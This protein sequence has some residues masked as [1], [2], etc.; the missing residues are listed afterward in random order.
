IIMP[1]TAKSVNGNTSVAPLSRRWAMS[2]AES[3]TTAAS[4][5]KSPPLV[6]RCSASRSTATSER[7]TM[8]P[9]R[10]SPGPSRA[11]DP[12]S[13][14]PMAN[15]VAFLPLLSTTAMNAA[16]S[17]R[18]VRPTWTGRRLALGTDA[19]IS[20]AAKAAPKTMIMGDR[21]AQSID[22]SLIGLSGGRCFVGFVLDELQ[23][24]VH[25]RFDGVDE[26]LRVEPEPDDGDHQR[27]D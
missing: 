25:G 15:A 11:T 2:A 14:P 23:G 12:R 5:T 24:V 19:S 16:A 27:R 13:V 10:N 6:V 1:P 8:V 7:I 3:A 4:A 17:V 21:P 9:C 26:R 22:I 18:T 20:R